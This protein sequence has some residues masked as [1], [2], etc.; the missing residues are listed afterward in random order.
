MQTKHRSQARDARGPG[1]F[2][3]GQAD[4]RR[5]PLAAALLIGFAGALSTACH[6]AEERVRIVESTVALTG[7]PEVISGGEDIEFRHIATIAPPMSPAGPL[8]ATGFDVDEDHHIY[9]AYN[10]AGETSYGGLDILRADFGNRQSVRLLSSAVFENYELAAVR[11]IG[12]VLVGVGAKRDQGAVLVVFQTNDEAPSTIR[13]ELSLAPGR[14]ATDL[15]VDGNEALVAVGD[16]AGIARVD[17]TDRDAPRLLSAMSLP[18]ATFAHRRGGA[19]IALGGSDRTSLYVEQGGVLQDVAILASTPLAAPHRMA[20]DA[21]FG[22]SNGGG[23]LTVLEF[24]ED[25]ASSGAVTIASRTP[26]TGTGNGIDADDAKMVYAAQGE[27]GLRVLNTC[28]P[29]EPVELGFVDF[30]DDGSANNVRITHV[31]LGNGPERVIFVA[32][33]LGGF[34]VVTR[35]IKMRSSVSMRA[36]GRSSGSG[37]CTHAVAQ[38]SAFRVPAS[39]TIT[40]GEAA[41]ARASLSFDGRTTC[42]YASRQGHRT[43]EL[44]ACSN[45]ARARDRVRAS[46]N[47][48][49]D[50]RGADGAEMTA[51]VA[52]DRDAS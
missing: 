5:G 20:F 25:F 51:E 43:L 22:Y 1:K 2:S 44:E 49:L 12:D 3:R 31:G 18:N 32:D 30:A 35:K 28:D 27:G 46:C 11:W 45:G 4:A 9:V 7:A 21:S 39:V 26:L 14:Y 37:R 24:G 47:V 8:Q 40:E 10:F 48:K 41:G 19:A 13:S 33:G 36:R 23:Q 52:L 42:S 38:E 16:N 17:L 15:A 34:R 29:A 6:A 50:V